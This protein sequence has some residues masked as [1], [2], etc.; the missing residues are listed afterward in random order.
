MKKNSDMVSIIIPVY[1]GADYMKEA[2]DSALDQTYANMEVIVIND[3]SKDGGITDEIARSYDGKIRYYV[4]ENGGVASALNL[5]IQ[6]MEGDFFSWLSHDD[7][8]YPRK[9]EKQ[10]R[11]FLDGLSRDTIVHCDSHVINEHSQVVG[12]TRFGRSIDENPYIIV[13]STALGGCSLLIPRDCFTRAGLFN[14]RLKMTQDTELWL[15]MIKAGMKL[16]YLPEILLKS[17][18]HPGQGSRRLKDIHQQEKEGFYSWA[19]DYLG[20]EVRDLSE[21]LSEVLLNKRCYR[22]LEKLACMTENSRFRTICRLKKYRQKSVDGM[23]FL[24]HKI[25]T[26]PD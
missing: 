19:M 13:L 17:R 14:E 2:I 23:R 3:G 15:R 11:F 1:N 12:T 25:R 5:G 26:L 21:P 7:V 20:T 16:S 4:K 22:A 18:I 24:A 10:V 9:I 6:V 8:Y